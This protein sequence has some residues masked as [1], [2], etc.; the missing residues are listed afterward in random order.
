MTA[1]KMMLASGSAADADDLGRLV[2]LEQAEVAA[3]R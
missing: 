2:H 3:R 1:P